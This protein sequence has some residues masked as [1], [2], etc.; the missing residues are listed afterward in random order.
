M[1]MDAGIVILNP[2]ADPVIHRLPVNKRPEPHTLHQPSDVDLMRV[3]CFAVFH[4]RGF[5]RK[6]TAFTAAAIQD[7]TSKARLIMLIDIFAG[8]K[9]DR[10][11]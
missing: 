10:W 11:K 9:T 6:N 4:R 1:D 2:S 3:Y 8:S 7:F 5:C